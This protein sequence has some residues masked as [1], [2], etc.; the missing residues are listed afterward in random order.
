M[1]CFKIINNICIDQE[2]I[3]V[4]L[5]LQIYSVSHFVSGNLCMLNDYNQK[6]N[7]SRR[8]VRDR[9]HSATG[10]NYSLLQIATYLDCS[11]NQPNERER[12]RERL[13]LYT[14]CYLLTQ[15]INDVNNTQIALMRLWMTCFAV[16][17]YY[18]QNYHH[19]DICLTLSFPL[20]NIITYSMT[21]NND[22]HT[23]THAHTWNLI[24]CCFFLMSNIPK[25]DHNTKIY[26]ANR[27]VCN[28]TSYAKNEWK[29]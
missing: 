11:N 25:G 19:N 17:C 15:M 12:G 6:L 1:P 10:W 14:M 23:H 8:F 21:D 28:V 29:R 3:A 26:T 18:Q 20:F 5:L 9:Q 16:N 4:F 27:T 22:I 7:S 2:I 24:E 13:M